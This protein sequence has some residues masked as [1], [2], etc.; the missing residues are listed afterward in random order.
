MAGYISARFEMDELPTSNQVRI[1]IRNLDQ[2]SVPPSPGPSYFPTDP[3]DLQSFLVLEYVSDAIGERYIRVADLADVAALNALPLNTLE[4][5]GVDFVAAGVVNGDVIE[6]V[7]PDT[8]LWNSEE[9]PSITYQFAVQS[10]LSSTQITI[11]GAFPAFANGL[12][13]SIATRSL[14]GTAGVTHREGSPAGGTLFRD[15]RFNR[16][17]TEAVAATN[18]VT[19][20]KAGMDALATEVTGAGL[21]SESYTASPS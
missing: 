19:A 21:V 12:N 11:A 7:Q 9:Y 13:W 15:T 5:V 4:D 6:I 2:G 8:E 17:F 18:Y 14:S 1:I 3:D 16:Y 10:V 20:V